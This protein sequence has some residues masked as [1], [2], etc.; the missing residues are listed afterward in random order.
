MKRIIIITSL[1]LIATT[2]L[3]LAQS[4][5]EKQWQEKIFEREK[6]IE[7]HIA[8]RAQ[9]MYIGDSLT[10]AIQIFKGE[11][12]L[13]VFQRQQL[14][15]LLK[16]SQINNQQLK[17]QDQ[18][19]IQTEKLYQDELQIIIQWHEG[20]IDSL[21]ALQKM[22]TKKIDGSIIKKL[23]GLK[24]E[25]DYYLKKLKPRFLKKVPG[26][27]ITISEFDSYQKI[28][29]KADLLKDQ[30]EKIRK[31]KQLLTSQTADLDNE[32]KLRSRMNELI[33]DTYLMDYDSDIPSQSA[34]AMD[35]KSGR[36]QNLDFNEAVYVGYGAT[37]ASPID[38]TDILI[39]YADVSEFS[40]MDLELYIQR[41]RAVEKQLGKSADSLQIKANL[42]YQAAEKKKKE[43][44]K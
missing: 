29:Q 40:T 6:Q 4:S 15:Q 24:T 30:E 13:N 7:N 23:A 32:L 42:F 27:T 39:L 38:A 5:Q 35:E 14:E 16:S 20:K 36:N 33:S 18:E 12:R 10:S 3:L 17:K 22:K 26:N 2:G 19:I 21:L 41:L 1:L 34:M 43:I 8:K 31:Q 28:R 44:K 37:E 11:K 25:R 9:L